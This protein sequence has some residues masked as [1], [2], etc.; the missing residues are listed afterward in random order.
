MQLMIAVKLSMN[1]VD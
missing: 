1:K